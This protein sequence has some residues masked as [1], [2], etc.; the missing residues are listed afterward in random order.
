MSKFL[1]LEPF[2][3]GTGLTNEIFFCI[4]GII[5]CIINKK[6]C[7]IINNFS[8]EAMKTEYCDIS[9]ILDLH[10]L[11]C[12]TKKYGLYVLD[13]NRITIDVSSIL[14][15][16]DNNMVDVTKHILDKCYNNGI[17]FI[18]KNTNLNSICGDHCVGFEK[19]LVINYTIDNISIAEEYSEYV[20]NDI[21][22][23]FINPK[24]IQ[25]WEQID[26]CY[27]EHNELFNYFLENIRFNNRF[28][29]YA[30]NAMLIDVNNNYTNMN[31]INLNNRKINVVHLRVEKD[32]TGHMLNSNKMKQ[33]E[34][35]RELQN[36]YI[37][38]INKFCSKEDILF[39]LSYDLKNSI[40]TYLKD[41]NYECYFTK[42]N[43]FNGREKHAIIDLLI[44]E[45][46]NN[47]FIGNWN[48]DTRQGSTFSYYLYIKNN[49]LQNV[50]IDMY[51][52]KKD[53]LIKNKNNINLEL[54]NDKTLKE[55]INDEE[56]DKNTSHSYL[57]LYEKL[58]SSK[59]NTAKKVLE[60]GIGDFK[61]KN[62]GSIK[63]WYKYF[64]NA[65]IYA[66]DILGPERVL[67]ELKNNDRIHIFTNSNG[68]DEEFFEKTFLNNNIKFDMML[69][70]GIHSLE[71]MKQFI[72]LYSQLM[73]DDGILMIEDVQTID[74]IAELQSVVPEHLKKY[75]EIYDL[76]ANK[77][78]WDDIVFVINKRK[79]IVDSFI[80]GANS[81]KYI[82]Q[83]DIKGA[84]VEC[85]VDGGKF[86]E[87]WINELLNNNALRDIYLYDTF[88]G[89]TEPGEND[90]TC[91]KACL[92]EMTKEEVHKKWESQVIND[93]IN[94]WCYTPLDIVKNKLN[95]TG[96]PKNNL[97]Y[98]VGDVMETLKDKN[99]IPERIAILRLDTDWYES[100][101]Y[102]LEQM[103]DNVVIGGLIIFDDYC[104]WNGQRLATEKFFEKRNIKYDVINTNNGKTA[105]IIK[106]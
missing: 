63:M 13:R 50:F 77:N 37:N 47:V 87:I 106:K 74:W 65:E 98:I 62:G 18:P 72:K 29:K 76:R 58:L 82:L 33:N 30:D 2:W 79:I 60:I 25:S 56:T 4:C 22:L 66:V 15:G 73:T 81:I 85:G 20:Q 24:Q 9:E 8:L 90:Y 21:M 38:L 45:K 53:A 54:E 71:S 49:A 100:S 16:I 55:L 17:L 48:F 28:V 105:V 26:K 75:I 36:K 44:G 3:L 104:H 61:E 6:T 57:D 97:H 70:D 88:S 23:D 5:D 41:N 12:L 52:I 51:D 31:M 69:D 43:I 14:Y 10:H 64:I 102:E 67:D 1:F 42:K 93:K 96:Y 68:Y 91:E 59:K 19:K 11:N 27:I 34:Y 40:I 94:G 99:N 103:Y 86:E 80:D 78:R 7:L 89:L 92:Y 32:M 35:D 39:V 101:R 84:I 46:C 95:S 83:N